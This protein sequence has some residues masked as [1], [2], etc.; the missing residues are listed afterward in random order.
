MP[1]LYFLVAQGSL[2][3]VKLLLTHIFRYGA[4]LEL[5]TQQEGTPVSLATYKGH[6][7]TIH[8]LVKSHADLDALGS[9]HETPLHITAFHGEEVVVVSLLQCGA[10]PNAAD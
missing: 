2:E 3:Q 7:K 6:M 9:L 8:L 1:P 4:S 5:P 10:N